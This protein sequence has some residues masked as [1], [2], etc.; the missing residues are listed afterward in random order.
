MLL[1]RGSTIQHC[2]VLASER[3]GRKSGARDGL[4]ISMSDFSIG[5]R[6]FR[7]RTG[8]RTHCTR[9]GWR[10]ES[11]Q[12]AKHRRV[13]HG[14]TAL[15]GPLRRQ[16]LQLIPEFNPGA[17][18]ERPELVAVLHQ[19]LLRSVSR[20]CEHM[21]HAERAS[22][23]QSWSAPGSG[24]GLRQGCGVGG[25]PCHG[26]SWVQIMM[27]VWHC[28]EGTMS[29]PGDNSADADRCLRV[30]PTQLESCPA[31]AT[32]QTL[33]QKFHRLYVRFRPPG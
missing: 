18:Q 4:Q 17:K 30:E 10:S 31:F 25:P 28:V 20:G 29:R 21:P 11:H 24:L 7:W 22:Q 19:R 27:R 32:Q 6:A 13:G 9:C 8:P 33:G 2:N 5:R 15:R 26:S 23:V 12:L 16:P 14:C 1:T 3:R